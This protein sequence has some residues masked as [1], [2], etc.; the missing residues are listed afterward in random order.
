MKIILIGPGMK[1]IPPTGWGAIESLIWDYYE[2]L[3]KLGHEVIIINELRLI[4]VINICNSQKPDAI[5]IMYDDY[6]KIVPH[7]K[8]NKIFYTSHYAFITNNNFQYEYKDY[9]YNIFLRVMQYQNRI[10]LNAL[11]S[12][13][14]DV[15]KKHG[16]TGKMFILSNGAREDLF[17]YNAQP[18]K[19]NKSIYVAKI[20]ERKGQ[21]KYQCINDI[22]FIGNY[23]DSPFDI[24]NPNYL[25]EWDKRTLYENLTE[26]G[27]LILLSGGEAD[28]LVTKEALVAGLGLVLSEVSC[29]NLDL[30]KNFITIIPDEKLDDIE[31]IEEKIKENREYSVN[32]R[33]EIRE[34]ALANF[35]WDSIITKYIKNMQTLH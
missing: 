34:Y 22:D 29:A 1:P 30:T 8:C 28:P 32:N 2:N 27:N 5:H 11:S 18:E 17:K 21:Y 26:Y 15:Y 19:Y 35:S 3:K 14:G 24:K 25:G 16:Y 23:H 10:Q 20:E 31:Y 4:K 33:N 13:I 12:T 9:F 7:L 6:I